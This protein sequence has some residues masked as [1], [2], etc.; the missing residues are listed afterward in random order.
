MSEISTELGSVDCNE[1]LP[2]GDNG[3]LNTFFGLSS[4]KDGLTDMPNSHVHI[5]YIARPANISS[6]SA[7]KTSD[8]N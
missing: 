4:Q 7:L 1:L 2:Q 5:C 3:V 8:A 6:Y